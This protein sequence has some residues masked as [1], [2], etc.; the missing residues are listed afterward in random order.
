VAYRSQWRIAISSLN[1]GLWLP[2][3]ISLAVS[4]RKRQ[5]NSCTDIFSEVLYVARR[6]FIEYRSWIT[7]FGQKCGVP[8][9][10][11]IFLNSYNLNLPWTHSYRSNKNTFYGI[12]SPRKQFVPTATAAWGLPVLIY[13]T[14]S[15]VWSLRNKTN[16]ARVRG[17]PCYQ[18]LTIIMRFLCSKLFTHVTQIFELNR[19]VDNKQ[20]STGH[21]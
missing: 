5:A 14:P 15:W 18:M 2:R 21:G 4:L 16:F 7:C 17:L 6:E 12:W 11:T 3:A 9:C 10:N 20:P 8:C 13:R 1:V 19:N